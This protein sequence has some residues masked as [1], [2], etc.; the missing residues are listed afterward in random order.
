MSLL[1]NRL[2][3]SQKAFGG[4]FKPLLIISMIDGLVYRRNFQLVGE[5]LQLAIDRVVSVQCVRVRL[6]SMA[7]DHLYH[8]VRD[9]GFG[10]SEEGVSQ[11]VRCDVNGDAVELADPIQSAAQCLLRSV[12]S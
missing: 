7:E 1:P 9:E 6:V 11:R 3:P 2:I 4:G 8:P 10:V 5:L 12:L